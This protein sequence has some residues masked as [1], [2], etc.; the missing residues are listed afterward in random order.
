MAVAERGPRTKSSCWSKVE[1]SF[2]LP[3]LDI[4]DKAGSVEFLH[5]IRCGGK[6]RRQKFSDVH[7]HF[8]ADHQH[9]DR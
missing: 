3:V 8:D 5:D 6:T 2:Y 9:I 7:V 1:S 4:T